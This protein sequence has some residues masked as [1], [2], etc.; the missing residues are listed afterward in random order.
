MVRTE[1]ELSDIKPILVT[2]A[3]RSGTTWVGKT[4]SA[5][6]EVGY[7]SEP[8]G[9][10]HRRG[11]MSA[12]IPHW[13]TYINPE[14]EQVYLPALQDTLKFNYHTGKEITSV[15]SPKDIGRMGR[16]FL[17]FYRGR[18]QK[19]RPLLKD[20]FAA[21]SAPWFSER[22]NSQVVFM[23]RHPAAFVSSLKRLDWNFDLNDLLAQ[24]LLMEDLLEPYRKE[25]TDATSEPYDLIKNGSILWKVLYGVGVL[26][27]LRYPDL[28]FIR[29]EDLAKDPVGSF[30]PIFEFLGI[31]YTPEI[32]QKIVSSTSSNNPQELSLSAKHSTKLNSAASLQNW[33]HR[34][35]IEEIEKIHSITYHV[36]E[37]YYDGED[38]H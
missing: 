7:I 13:Y 24:K 28:L 19:Q 35:S 26:F 4:L 27:R 23:V 2:G 16:D 33:K 22:L 8:L 9:V 32:I 34:L 29:H 30:P 3:H 12:E 31:E 14:N 15:R 18:S 1:P 37:H 11:V 5:S 36:A 25:I 6:S 10:Y 17:A 21:F 38:W 20:P